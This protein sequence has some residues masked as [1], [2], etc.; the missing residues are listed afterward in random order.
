MSR[1]GNTLARFHVAHLLMLLG[2]IGAAFLWKSGVIKKI[3]NDIVYRTPFRIPGLPPCPDCNIVLVNLDS[4]RAPNLPCYGYSRN[5]TPNLCAYAK[6]NALFTRFYSQSSVT[7]DSH[8][9]IFTGLYPST[10]HVV[11]AFKDSLN[12]SISTLTQALAASG[13]RTIWAGSTEDILLPLDKGLG[14]GFSEIYHMNG[15]DPRMYEPLLSKLTDGPPTFIFFH[16]YSPHSPYLPGEGPRQY[17]EA[18]KGTNIPVTAE[19]FW[20]HDRTFYV[21]MLSE[22]EKRLGNSET[23]QSIVRNTEVVRKLRAALQERDMTLAQAVFDALPLFEQYDLSITWYYRN[24]DPKN[25]EILTYLEGLYDEQLGNV[26]KNISAM[27]DFLSKPE[28]KRKTIVIF[29]SDNG[30]EFME[31][32]FVDHGWSIYS[33]ETHVPGI[34]A[35]PKTQPGIYHELSQTVDLYPTVLDL[36]GIKPLAPFEGRSLRPILEGR[37]EQHV[38]DTYVVGQHRADITVSIRNNRWKM[39]K[40]N[41]LNKQYTELY[42]L[43]TDPWEQQNVLGKHQDIAVRLDEALSRIMN[44]SPVY[45]SVSGEFPAWLDESKRRELIEEGY[46]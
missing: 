16:S 11:E 14:R 1:F 35:A 20:A 10:H 34:I 21:F 18:P 36:V 26:D 41:A 40:N 27:L 7:L 12:P 19:D 13:Y 8:M 24:A 31:H 2:I 37:G 42:D 46:F 4:M 33:V 17:V 45:A 3:R 32:G 29:L 43:M 44:A 30:E 6:K 39:Y 28:I 9:S 22:F 15:A 25:P 38:G 5:T 23:E